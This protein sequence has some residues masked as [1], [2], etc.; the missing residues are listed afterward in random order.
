[1]A[2]PFTEYLRQTRGELRHVAWPTR[3]QTIIYAVLVGAIS[4][5]TALYLGLF[6]FLFTTGLTRLLNALPQG[7][8][9]AITASS[10]SPL[11]ITP[12]AT[13][14]LPAGSDQVPT[15]FQ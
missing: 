5:G 12:I 13:G 9:S 2:N 8:P 4:I 15:P 11:T 10:T 1:M 6:D 14:T 3:A 7:A